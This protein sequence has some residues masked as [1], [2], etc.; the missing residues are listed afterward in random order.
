[1]RL[2]AFES[3]PVPVDLHSS[4]NLLHNELAISDAS[5][6]LSVLAKRH[7]L[8]LPML[9]CRSTFSLRNSWLHVERADI[10][11]ALLVKEIVSFWYT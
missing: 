10:M 3:V 11:V 8:S 2:L 6:R 1:M 7:T 5:T 9:V 4:W